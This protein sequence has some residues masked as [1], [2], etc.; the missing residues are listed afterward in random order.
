MLANTM[1]GE[2][3]GSTPDIDR[4][5]KSVSKR[6]KPS[7]LRA[8]G[9]TISTQWG[10][11]HNGHLEAKKCTLGWASS[12]TS[13]LWGHI[14]GVWTAA[15]MYLL[16]RRRWGGYSKKRIFVA[17]CLWHVG[18]LGT[19]GNK[20]AL[21]AWSLV[22]FEIDKKWGGDLLYTKQ[23][24]F[25][26]VFHFLP[27]RR[28]SFLQERSR[29][30]GE[31][32]NENVVF[33]SGKRRRTGLRIPFS[34][35]NCL[36]NTKSLSRMLVK[37]MWSSVMRVLRRGSPVIPHGIALERQLPG[38][39]V[40]RTTCPVMLRGVQALLL[41]VLCLSLKLVS[42]KVALSELFK[43]KRLE[44]AQMSFESMDPIILPT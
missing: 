39:Y 12:P 27:Y 42:R 17:Y 23:D 26:K 37:Q 14:C 29:D 1:Y 6:K 7:S 40:W 31:R 11:E 4:G 43:G 36:A 16:S 2:L 30:R 8:M 28:S 19:L 33:S 15:H 3:V 34:C 41:E 13:T 18:H 5:A 22:C 24:F 32:E 9:R 25:A 10:L 20:N 44:N 21:K 35:R 38:C